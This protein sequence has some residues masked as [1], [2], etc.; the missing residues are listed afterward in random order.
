MTEELKE[1]YKSFKDIM[2][3]LKAISE[4]SMKDVTK[5]REE[6]VSIVPQAYFL[7]SNLVKE[8]GLNTT[9]H[10]YE[11]KGKESFEDLL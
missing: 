10:N 11:P 7:T 4:S 8:I 3:K 6:L 9:I 5:N 2:P 1:L